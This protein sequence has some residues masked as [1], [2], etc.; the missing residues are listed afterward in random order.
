MS[1]NYPI[2]HMKQSFGFVTVD[3]NENVW[4]LTVQ[5]K[6]SSPTAHDCQMVMID[7]LDTLHRLDTRLLLTLLL[8]LSP[9]PGSSKILLVKDDDRY[10][11]P[12]PLVMND[13]R[14]SFYIVCTQSNTRCY[15]KGT[16][17]F[18]DPQSDIHIRFIGYESG[19]SDKSDKSDHCR[20]IA[21][22]WLISD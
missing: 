11:H 13:D 2:I 22:G 12:A 21:Y 8:L 17:I 5:D 16:L 3:V 6:S 7:R 14:W 10:I 9:I 18:Q 4:P 19:Q 15:P 1:L 20:K